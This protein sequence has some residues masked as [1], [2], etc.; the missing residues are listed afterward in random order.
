MRVA[1]K[2]VCASRVKER[3]TKIL[4][5]GTKDEVLLF[6]AF[7][8]GSMWATNHG[9]VL[10]NATF[11]LLFLLPKSSFGENKFVRDDSA[12]ERLRSSSGDDR[13]DVGEFRFGDL[14]CMFIG[15]FSHKMFSKRIFWKGEQTVKYVI[16]THL[17]AFLSPNRVLV[18][19]IAPITGCGSIVP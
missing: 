7:F 19:V 12:D 6:E 10:R 14:Y 16:S 17:L 9:K 4:E 8:K 5:G 11:H 1:L 2:S 15:Y 3:Q 18:R 13:R